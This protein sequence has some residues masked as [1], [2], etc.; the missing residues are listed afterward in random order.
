MSIKKTRPKK[1]A[2]PSNQTVRMSS[3]RGP[4]GLGA[5]LPKTSPPLVESGKSQKKS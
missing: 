5:I 2:Q 4:A 3:D 1:T